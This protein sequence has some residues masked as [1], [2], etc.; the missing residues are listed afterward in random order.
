M[1][2][3]RMLPLKEVK[4]WAEAA[5]GWS[6]ELKEGRRK[7]K[8]KEKYQSLLKD[9][10]MQRFARLLLGE[11]TYEEDREWAEEALWER[12]LLGLPY[13]L[14]IKTQ[15]WALKPFL[16]EDVDRLYHA[17]RK[18]RES[19]LS[20]EVKALLRG[21]A[22]LGR[23]LAL[24]EEELKEGK[25]KCMLLTGFHLL[26]KPFNTFLYRIADE[27]GEGKIEKVVLVGGRAGDKQLVKESVRKA[28][29]VQFRNTSTL[30]EAGG[31]AEAVIIVGKLFIVPFSAREIVEVVEKT[32]AHYTAIAEPTHHL[33]SSLTHVKDVIH[34]LKEREK[35]T[36]GWVEVIG[37]KRDRELL[38]EIAMGVERGE[39]WLFSA[40]L[41]P[42]EWERVLEKVG[43]VERKA[44]RGRDTSFFAGLARAK[45]L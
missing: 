11:L 7:G 29:V 6:E 44:K 27:V 17:L 18:P 10:A 19:N 34:A 37:N 9:K 25:G 13:L 12:D 16:E 32:G 15:L 26:S 14:P 24:V 40:A 42:Q 45:G 35:G 21:I 2:Y 41:P 22:E 23:E 31:R 33:F 28:K 5:K 8:G 4:E 20:G 3:S 1:A 39:R 38:E 30:L 36:E 43:K